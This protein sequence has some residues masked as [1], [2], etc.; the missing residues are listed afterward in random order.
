MSYED[1]ITESR[2]LA[3]LL[4]LYFANAYTLNRSVLRDQVERTGYVTAMKEM[5]GELEWLVDRGLIEELEHDVV[6]LTY[7]GEDAALGRS[8]INGVR[9]PS[10]AVSQDR[11]PSVKKPLSLL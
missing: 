8:R 7:E 2:R 5:I 10:P 6:R 9:R 1:E 3:I 4:A 11:N